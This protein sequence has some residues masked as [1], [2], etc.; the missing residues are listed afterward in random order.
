MINHQPEGNSP[1][2]TDDRGVLVMTARKADEILDISQVMLPFGL[3]L[4]KATLVRLAAGEVL[5][6]RLQDADTLQ[7]LLII[8]ERSGER[9]LACEQQGGY[10][11]VWIQKLLESR[12]H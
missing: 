9:V 5:E 12:T 11:Q 1:L 4:C 6:I 2:K 3:V 10:Y 7:D 8:L